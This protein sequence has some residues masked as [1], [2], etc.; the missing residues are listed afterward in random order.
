MLKS[1]AGTVDRLV[2]VV[3]GALLMAGW[4]Y[5][6]GTTLGWVMLVVGIIALATGLLGSCPLYSVLGI[7]TS[8]AKES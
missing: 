5:N 6:Q 1:N 7:N 3:L 8:K 2:R 4:M